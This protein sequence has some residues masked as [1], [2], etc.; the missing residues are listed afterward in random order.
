MIFEKAFATEGTEITE[1][2]LWR[3]PNTVFAQKVLLLPS[4]SLCPLCPL[5]QEMPL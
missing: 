5:W 1:E 4:F 2:R 3:C